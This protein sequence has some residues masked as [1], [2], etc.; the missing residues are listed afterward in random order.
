MTF[1][2]LTALP[3]APARTDT[4]EI[5]ITRADAFVAALATLRSEFNTNLVEIAAVAA[6]LGVSSADVELMALAGL[7][8]AADR[9]PYFTGSGTA[10]LAT[11][12]A[13]A[14][15][16]LDDADATTMLSTLGLSANGKSLVTAADYAAMRTLLSVYT[17]AQVDSAVA[18]AQAAAT[19]AARVP[20]GIIAD[21]GNET[22]P[23]GWLECNGAAVSRAT[24][25]DLFTAVGIKWGAGD[26]TTTFNVPDFRG[27]F[28]RGWD[29]GRGVDSGRA[30]ASAQADELESHTHTL[31]LHAD[32]QINHDASAE[33]DRTVDSSGTPTAGYIGSTGG[34]ETRPRNVATLVCIKT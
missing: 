21:F 13:A 29:N 23:T 2:P 22:P 3:T 33:G 26:T 4:P 24:Y 14:R 6:A 17:Q 25:A 28:R 27:E 34:T 15:A 32:T 9:V 18:A 8:S 30:F 10:S 7:T 31:E 1:T 20:A 16:L 5:F 11:F 12:T 19:A